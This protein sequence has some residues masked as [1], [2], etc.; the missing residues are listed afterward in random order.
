MIIEIVIRI[1]I[2]LVVVTCIA[3]IVG[4]LYFIFGV[5]IPEPYN[6]YT[7]IGILSIILFW[8]IGSCVKDMSNPH[9]QYP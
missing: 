7:I 4:L 6:G 1:G 9:D 3:L 2:G 5:A 8:I